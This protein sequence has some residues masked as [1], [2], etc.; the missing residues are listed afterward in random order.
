MCAQAVSRVNG[1]EPKKAD[2]GRVRVIHPGNTGSN[3]V[4]VA[5]YD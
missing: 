4:G 3:P 2:D 5:F 1:K